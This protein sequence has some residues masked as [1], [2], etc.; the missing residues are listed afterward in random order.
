[1]SCVHWEW[2]QLWSNSGTNMAVI[3]TRVETGESSD[4]GVCVCVLPITS[5]FVLIAE[6]ASTEK[7]MSLEDVV[8]TTIY[9]HGL[10]GGGGGGVSL[11]GCL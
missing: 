7:Q 3:R 5:G 6:T 10:V 9:P 1:M 11:W 4:G 2:E 8:I